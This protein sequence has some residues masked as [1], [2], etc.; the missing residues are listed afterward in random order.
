LGV[1]EEVSCA[2]ANWIDG[3]AHLDKAPEDGNPLDGT[4]RRWPLPNLWLGVS[5]EDQA[6]ADERIPHLLDCPAAGRFVSYEP[7]L[8]PVDFV[9]WFTVVMPEAYGILSKFYGPRGFDESGVQPERRLKINDEIGIHWIIAGGE[10]GPG[11]RPAHPDWFRKVR[12]ECKAAGVPFFFK[13]WG[14]W[15]FHSTGA[16]I[17]PALYG[18]KIHK[19]EDGTKCGLVVKKRAGHLLDHREHHAFP[20]DGV[21]ADG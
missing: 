8:G 12:D 1:S 17:H 10:S 18:K 19:F 2:V 4:V 16:G 5:V 20:F 3:W 6:T 7:A 21:V 11:A 13:Q 15:G 14:A 9:K